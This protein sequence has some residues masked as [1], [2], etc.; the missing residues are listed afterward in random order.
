MLLI[1]RHVILFCSFL[2]M[3]KQLPL[4]QLF[5]CLSY[6]SLMRF[7]QK[8]CCQK[9][10]GWEKKIKRGDGHIGGLPIE[11]G[12]TPSAHYSILKTFIEKVL[13][14]YK[15]SNIALLSLKVFPFF[16]LSIK[17]SW[18]QDMHQRLR[19]RSL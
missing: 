18:I 1:T 9:W 10:G 11:G 8:K 7:F 2:N 13:N 17:Q 6:I 15:V 5:L 12:F 3:K 19:W 16:I 14:I 4:M